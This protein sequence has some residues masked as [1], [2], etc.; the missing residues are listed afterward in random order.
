[1]IKNSPKQKDRNKKYQEK[2]IQWNEVYPI[3]QYM[4]VNSV[5]ILRKEKL[6]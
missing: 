4:L 3:A 5:S 1:M 6:T 2:E